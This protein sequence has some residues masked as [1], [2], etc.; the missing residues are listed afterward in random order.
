MNIFNVI[1][2]FGG[3]A[4]FL[5]GMRMMGDGLK[6]SSSGPLK[7]AMERI[8]GTPLKAFLLGL[9]VTAV[10]QSSKATIVLTSGL[11]GTGIISLHQSLGIIIGANV[12]TTV[13]GQI[14]RLLDLNASGAWFL[15]F[16]QPSSLAPLALIIGSLVIAGMKSRDSGKIG[17][18]IVGFG[19]LFTGL[20]NMTDAV[21]VLSDSGIVEQLFSRLGQNPLL[22]CLMGAAWPLCSRAPLPPWVSSRHSP[23]QA[24]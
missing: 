24:S 9:G 1:T 6:A 18:I 2:L 16:F 7:K 14:I 4:M 13:T 21:S 23:P 5:Y 11:V 17:H 15:K 8:T 19:I 20:L 3:L 10:I 22:A 12:G